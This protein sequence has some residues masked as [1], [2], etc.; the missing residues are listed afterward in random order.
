MKAI[1]SVFVDLW[2]FMKATR[3][4]YLSLLIAFLLLMGAV[5]VLS[6]GSALMPFIYTIF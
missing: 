5:V 6:E 4:I 2:G 1:L 3:K